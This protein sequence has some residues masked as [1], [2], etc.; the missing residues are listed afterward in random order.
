M[1]SG[2]VAHIFNVQPLQGGLNGA[3]EVKKVFFV[4]LVI[5]PGGIFARAGHADGQAQGFVGQKLAFDWQEY[6]PSSNFAKPGGICD[7]A[8]AAPAWSPGCCGAGQCG[9]GDGILD[10]HVF[11]RGV[12][13]IF[14]PQARF[15]FRR[16]LAVG[17]CILQAGAHQDVPDALFHV[18]LGVACLGWQLRG[19]LVAGRRS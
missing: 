1:L 7:C 15:A 14:R 17:N 9:R 13:G 19:E 5:L 2:S 10:A 11:Q 16:G 6:R 3:L 18:Q 8:L 12:E 4:R